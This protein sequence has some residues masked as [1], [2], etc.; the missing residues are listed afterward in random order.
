MAPSGDS[1]DL[2]F[3]KYV[4]AQ[5]NSKIGCGTVEVKAN[6]DVAVLGLTFYALPPGPVVVSEVL[7]DCWAAL[8]GLEPGDMV[9]AI[10]SRNMLTLH[11]DEFVRLIQERPLALSVVRPNREADQSGQGDEFPA[12]AAF[13]YSAVASLRKTRPGGASYGP[14]HQPLKCNI[15]WPKTQVALGQT[16]PGGKAYGPLHKLLNRMH[17][18]LSHRSV[19]PLSIL[20]DK[21][22]F[23]I[24]PSVRYA[25]HS[26]EVPPLYERMAERDED[27]GSSIP[28]RPT[29]ATQAHA[30]SSALIARELDVAQALDASGQNKEIDTHIS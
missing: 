12:A 10:Q 27:M 13:H 26:K 17:A 6:G 22:L 30:S 29:A 2:P 14:L 28:Q 19:V 11:Q 23:G 4:R 15:G 8:S 3:P 18:Q 20:G 21:S 7:P 9:T 1:L 25:S 24:E 5:M 16:R